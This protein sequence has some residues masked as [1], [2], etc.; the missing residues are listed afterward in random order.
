MND[1]AFLAQLDGIRKRA[2][3][4]KSTITRLS[5]RDG[6]LS[7]ELTKQRRTK[8][9]VETFYECDWYY[10]GQCT[11]N[12]PAHR[13]QKLPIQRGVQGKLL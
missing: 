8:A 13:G 1:P 11:C 5:F 4:E 3:R 12:P 2:Q 10:G 6:R 7:A 9:K